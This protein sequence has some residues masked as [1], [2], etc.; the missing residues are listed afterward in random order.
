MN[1]SNTQ[2][3]NLLTIPTILEKNNQKW[4][5]YVNSC[6]Q[7]EKRDLS[8][9]CNSVLK[10]IQSMESKTD[11]Q[12]SNHKSFQA[13]RLRADRLRNAFDIRNKILLHLQSIKEN[14]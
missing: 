13:D 6:N 5:E 2:S 8:I 3:T 10:I 4:I 11:I 12:L 1:Q 9:S 7:E 14:Y